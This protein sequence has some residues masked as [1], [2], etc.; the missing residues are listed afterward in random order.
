MNPRTFI[1]TRK[2]VQAK[3][4][5]PLID[6]LSRIS[7]YPTLDDQASV[8]ILFS[9]YE[10]TIQEVYHI[11]EIRDYVHA[12]DQEW[13]YMFYFMELSNLQILT[14][15]LMANVANIRDDAN[16]PGLIGLFMTDT[17]ENMKQFLARHFA[18]MNIKFEDAYE[19]NDLDPYSPEAEQNIANREAAI[20]NATREIIETLF[21]ST[22]NPQ[23]STIN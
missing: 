17:P 8:T 13:P 11:Q 16:R 15:C 6:I 14:A 18:Y 3:N 1:I 7:E 9:G 10:S 12:L 2:T 19:R 20:E 4:L 5:K 21:P 22:L 23:P